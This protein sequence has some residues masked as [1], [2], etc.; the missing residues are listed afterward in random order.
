MRK[1]NKDVKKGRKKRKRLSVARWNGSA[2]KLKLSVNT[3]HGFIVNK[4]E[5][6]TVFSALSFIIFKIFFKTYFRRSFVSYLFLFSL[7]SHKKKKF[8]SEKKKKKSEVN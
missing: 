3:L 7:H 2:V 1:Q 5:K 4:K 6:K 8:I